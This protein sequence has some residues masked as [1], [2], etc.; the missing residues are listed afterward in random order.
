MN[1]AAPSHSQ[2]SIVP[3]GAGDLIDRAIRFYRQNFA[4]LVLIALPPVAITTLLSLG[5]IQLSREIFFTGGYD[6]IESAAYAVFA[7]LGTIVIWLAGTVAT[8][9]VMGGASRNFVRHLLFGEAITFAATYRNIR[10]RFASLVLASTLIAVLL[11]FFGSIIFY[12]G[13]V[14]S[15]VAVSMVILVLS[16]IPIL[17]AII[18]VAIGLA[19]LLAT[20]LFFCL[21]ASRVA[22]V[23]Q[24]MMVEG[25]GI[26]AS[27]G[28]SMS[29]A[30]GNVM[31][32]AAL[33]AFTT[34]ATYSALAILYIPLG[35]Y[36]WYSGV[37]MLPLSGAVAPG[38]YEVASQ[39]VWQA[40]FVLM[41]PV[42]MIGLCLLYVDERV[43]HEGYDIELMAAARLGE[44]PSVPAAYSNPLQPALGSQ[45][46][47]A[48]GAA[49]P[50]RPNSGTSPLGLS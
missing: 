26:F 7:F 13:L 37:D 14:V 15:M 50:V 4:V 31:R 21:L 46:A 48:P 24:V 22:Y 45:Q 25:Q 19:S 8:L 34:L 1:S 2:M 23:P 39:V 32:F 20:Y 44:I 42:W 17:A 28:R 36:A 47:A 41:S 9:A 33:F 3:L 27:I 6:P 11:G 16:A 30:G 5:W 38:W 49:Q 10:E 18:S 40:S 12:F 29:L 35:W 43:R